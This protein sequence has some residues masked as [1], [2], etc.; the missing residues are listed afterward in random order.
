[1]LDARCR[2]VKL[3]GHSLRMRFEKLLSK[4]KAKGIAFMGLVDK[5]RKI[6]RGMIGVCILDIIKDATE[7]CPVSQD[8]IRDLLESS[9][10]IKADRK[11]VHR[12]LEDIVESVG[13]VRYAERTRVVKGQKKSMMTDF[14]FEADDEF[15]EAELRA[16]IYTVIFAKHIPTAI[17][18]DLVR[19]LE[20]LS[21]TDLHRKMGNYILEDENTIGDYNGLFWNIEILSEAIEDQR[22]VSFQYTYYEADRKIHVSERTLTVTPLG[23]A[24]REDDFYLLATV[25]GAKNDGIEDMKAHFEAVIEAI[26]AGEVR[27]DTFRIDRIYG[28][29]LLGESNDRLDDPDALRLRG[30]NRGQLDV[31]EYIRENPSLKSGHSVRAKLRLTEGQQ[32][33]ISDVI[34]H[35]G[36]ANVWVFAENASGKRGS[37]PFVISV[38]ANDGAIRDFVLRN[39]PCIEV[40]KPDNLRDELNDI[41]RTAL[42]RMN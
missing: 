2:A 22:Q 34:D 38:R 15:E 19:K 1:M 23:I 14:W 11:T 24:V 4:S 8:K 29:A 42:E 21:S 41:Y 33:T 31:Q 10:G 32:C 7:I 13:G 18:K 25:N 3:V 6:P 16:L 9:Y 35:F 12:Y 26:R 27:V 5:N 28:V 17:K 40:I 36:K 37:G 39:A 20:D 30:A